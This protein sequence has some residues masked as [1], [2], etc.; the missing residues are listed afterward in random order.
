[1]GVDLIRPE[2]GLDRGLK[3]LMIVIGLVL[4]ATPLAELVVQLTCGERPQILLLGGFCLIGILTVSHAT[5]GRLAPIDARRVPPP[6]KS[7]RHLAGDALWLPEG[8]R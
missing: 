1:M 5:R 6:E 3:K 4:M 2:S 8:E 7:D